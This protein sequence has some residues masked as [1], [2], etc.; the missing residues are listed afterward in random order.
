LRAGSDAC[1]TLRIEADVVV[2]AGARAAD[3]PERTPLRRNA[4]GGIAADPITMETS[5]PRVFAAGEIAAGP[6]GVIEAMA[7]GRRAARGVRRLLG[8]VPEPTIPPAE[9]AARETGVPMPTR[10]GDRWRPPTAPAIASRLDEPDPGLTEP[11]AVAEAKRCLM[12]GPCEEC[13]TCTPTCD[14]VL[15]DA[16][17]TPLSASVDPDAC[18]ACGLCSEVCP[19]SIPRLVSRRRRTTVAA[20]DP[21]RCRACGLCV[22]ACPT[23]AISQEGW[24]DAGEPEV[25]R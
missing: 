14:F 5:V 17:F 25:R 13:R 16:E 7:S 9:A 2:T 11:Q 19:W 3:L 10:G 21:A 15:V 18:V 4:L 1:G 6:R 24:P 12:C 22:G 20:V 8:S 23:E